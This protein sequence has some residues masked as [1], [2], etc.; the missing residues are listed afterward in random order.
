MGLRKKVNGRCARHP[1]NLDFYKVKVRSIRLHRR[2]NGNNQIRKQ[3]S[4]GL[5]KGNIWQKAKRAYVH[6]TKE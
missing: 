4:M 2:I 6:G 1:R 5:E 3:E